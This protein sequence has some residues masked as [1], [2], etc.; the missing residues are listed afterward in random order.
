[1]KRKTQ[2]IEILMGN[3]IMENQEKGGYNSYARTKNKHWICGDNSYGQCSLDSR[4][5]QKQKNIQY[6]LPCIGDIFVQ[7]TNKRIQKVY[8]QYDPVYI[9]RM[10]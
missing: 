9:T 7:R 6:L 10:M 2:I 1:M 4:I 3:E 5:K 8:L